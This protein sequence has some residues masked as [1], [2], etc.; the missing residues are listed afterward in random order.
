MDQK[1]LFIAIAVSLAILLG[2]QYLVAPH[3]ARPPQHNALQLNQEASKHPVTTPREG[4]PGGTAPAASAASETVPK[5]VPRV[6]IDGPR[7]AGSISLL[8]AR[9]DDIVL[10]DYHETVSPNSPLVQLLEPRS[11]AHPYYVQY[12]WTAPAGETVKLPDNNTVW[13]AS[14]D[15][16]V[17][18]KPVDLTWDNGAGLTF[19][20]GLAI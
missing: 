20:I 9:I 1:R 3:I 15:T 13:A 17:P 11:E 16:L 2:F 14:A 5:N 8:G 18:G 4:A 6:K 19:Q 7:I 12:G 10:K